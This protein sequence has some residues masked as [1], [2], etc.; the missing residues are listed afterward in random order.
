MFFDTIIIE[1]VQLNNT[2][3]K[4]DIFYIVVLLLTFI[5][6]IVGATFAIYSFILACCT[7]GSFLYFIAIINYIIS[8]LDIRRGFKL[9]KA[10]RRQNNNVTNEF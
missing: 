9:I 10:N 2:A 5:T 1:V 6:V 4:K 3:N 8:V 7:F